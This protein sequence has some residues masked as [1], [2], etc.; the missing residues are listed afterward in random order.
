MQPQEAIKDTKHRTAT[1]IEQMLRLES[2]L[3]SMSITDF[4]IE[5]DENGNLRFLPRCPYCGH[6]SG[7]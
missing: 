4:A 2:M 7:M 6:V 3:G 1:P 5:D